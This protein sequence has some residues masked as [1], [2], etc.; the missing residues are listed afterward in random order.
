LLS[1]PGIAQTE[2]EMLSVA[3]YEEEVAGNLDVAK[4]KYLEILEVEHP[5]RSV[6]AEALYRLANIH[7]NLG[8]EHA[9]K[10]L[11]QIISE[12]SDQGQFAEKA[13]LKLKEL[14]KNNHKNFD[15][16]SGKDE[17]FRFRI[18]KVN[19]NGSALMEI[20]PDGK[21]TLSAAPLGN[22][23]IY[24]LETET[25]K[26]LTPD[27]PNKSGGREITM[28]LDGFTGK[29]IWSKDSRKIVYSW[30]KKDQ[31]ND[32]KIYDLDKDTFSI[33]VSNLQ[34][35]D[36]TIPLQWT[37]RADSV[38]CLTWDRLNNSSV[39]F[40]MDAK[41]KGFRN[42]KTVQIVNNAT[43]AL[44]GSVSHDGNLFLY[45]KYDEHNRRKLYMQNLKTGEDIKLLEESKGHE[46]SPLWIDNNSFFYHGNRSG[47]YALWKVD[48]QNLPS[49][50]EEL[51]VPDLGRLYGHLGITND[52]SYY[53][54]SSQQ[55]QNLMIC[56]VDFDSKI[57]S[58][59]ELL[60]N[61]SEQRSNP[62]W[63]PDGTKIA[64]IHRD[65]LDPFIEM[66]YYDM[67]IKKLYP[68]R[69]DDLDLGRISN[70]PLTWSL[71]SKKLIFGTR[72]NTYSKQRFAFPSHSLDIA[73]GKTE[74]IVPD[75][76]LPEYIGGDQVL[77]IKDR[78]SIISRNL[79]SREEK[80]IYEVSG[81][82]I[83]D[84]SVSPDLSKVIIHTTPDSTVGRFLSSLHCLNLNTLELTTVW[85]AVN[86][87]LIW[88]LKW[89]NNNNEVL[90][91]YFEGP[92][93]PQEFHLI[94]VSSKNITKLT[95]D[96]DGRKIYNRIRV[97]LN[98][99]NDRMV[100][101]KQRSHFGMY[102]IESFKN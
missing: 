55:Y 71:D 8:E 35:T 52:S 26:K 49:V 15:N 97:S 64:Y 1:I 42:I 73:T 93:Q 13:K 54:W 11:D 74:T 34:S 86:E 40:L 78:T 99:E 83:L 9:I 30:N 58:P 3:I 56:K 22:L 41:T 4:E 19:Y 29:C 17:S 80:S 96:N 94:N 12:Y 61:D 72:L 77:F 33:L 90:F 102:K 69:R 45:V 32:L 67:L 66:G 21:Y 85:N 81:H 60:I 75:G 18:S 47:K 57:M 38:L 84:F 95:V 91:D 5:D 7:L 50:Q 82:S 59:G 28:N 27:P 2:R 10:Y 16:N 98:P 39:Y 23:A 92:P 6:V 31:G 101:L 63:S 14:R 43:G 88:E 36:Y 65:D 46:N 51:I 62:S 24:N 53:Y 44:R 70:A 48:V 100:Y 87:E 25:L 89:L 79:S 37:S 68:V 20:S 76:I